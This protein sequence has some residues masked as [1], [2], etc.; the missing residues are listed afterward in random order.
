MR[1]TL[2]TLIAY[3]DDVL[4]PNQ[5]KEIGKKL[6]ESSY[7]SSLV[8]RIKDVMRRRRLTAPEI[9]GAGSN[10]DANTIAEYLDNTLTPEIVADVEKVCLNSDVNLVEVAASHQILTLVLGEPA[11][12]NANTRERIYALGPIADEHV[13]GSVAPG[14]E[15]A[16]NQN[17]TTSEPG[18][19]PAQD[20]LRS[21]VPAKD[22]EPFSS[23]IPDYLKTKP[24]WKRFTPYFLI[25]LA[26]GVWAGLFFGD[27][28]F[29]SNQD[30][31]TQLAS[32]SQDNQ[33][34]PIPVPADTEQT[35]TGSAENQPVTTQTTATDGQSSTKTPQSAPMDKKPLAFDAPPPADAENE[36]V[37]KPN[38]TKTPSVEPPAATQTV[39]TDTT[40][41]K[42]LSTPPATTAPDKTV[43]LNTAN[44]PKTKSHK[45]LN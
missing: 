6:E 44:I 15:T 23:R 16:P 8:D 27:P 25:L 29:F 33:V 40:K 4:E 32:H 28:T 30:T 37:A 20:P 10:P 31:S 14:V 42:P 26:A 41:T 13:L 18:Q 43:A 38:P 36:S 24:L 17:N 19:Q 1:L 45:K 9:E 11:T 7:A 5:I 12:V 39:K 3:L 21:S 34:A 22:P 35:E 2:R